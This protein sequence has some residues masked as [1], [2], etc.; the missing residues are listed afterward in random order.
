MKKVIST[1]LCIFLFHLFVNVSVY[2]QNMAKDVQTPLQMKDNAREIPHFLDIGM[3]QTYRF[4][5]AELKLISSERLRQL[6]EIYIRRYYDI[7]LYFSRNIIAKQCIEGYP[8]EL[9]DPVVQ[10]TLMMDDNQLRSMLI[11]FYHHDE[12]VTNENK[13]LYSMIVPIIEKW[14]IKSLGKIKSIKLPAAH[15][16][17]AIFLAYVKKMGIRPYD[18]YPPF[19]PKSKLDQFIK[20]DSRKH[21]YFE[22]FIIFLIG[23][24]LGIIFSKNFLKSNQ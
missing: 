8:P 12:G 4:T 13:R 7:Y 3:F 11:N 17:N 2:G 16:P 5:E 19:Y 23:L 14:E 18:Y 9:I 10:Q 21:Q 24:F 1:I 6:I 15:S 22:F 20:E